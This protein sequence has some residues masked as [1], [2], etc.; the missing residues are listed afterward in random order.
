MAQVLAS[1]NA[2]S[3]TIGDVYQPGNGVLWTITQ[4]YSDV[5]G[6]YEWAA[7]RDNGVTLQNRNPFTGELA[8]HGL[9]S[10]NMYAPL[11]FNSGT[12]HI[13]N[14]NAPGDYAQSC[15]V[16]SRVWNDY[17][18][19]VIPEGRAFWLPRTRIIDFVLN[20]NDDRLPMFQDLAWHSNSGLYAIGLAGGESQSFQGKRDVSIKERNSLLHFYTW[21]SNMASGLC[22][23]NTLTRNNQLNWDASGSPNPSSPDSFYS[24]NYARP[25]YSHIEASPTGTWT[26]SHPYHRQPYN[27]SVIDLT[28]SVNRDFTWDMSVSGVVTL[29]FSSPQGGKAFL[30]FPDDIYQYNPTEL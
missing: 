7:T 8:A 3:G 13:I 2:P 27:V 18:V 30:E 23:V 24:W 16:L 4:V 6:I 12:L 19:S 21:S 22:V 15:G 25:V 10:G 20:P 17:E 14:W 5:S 29:T 28:A 11:T 1:K 26:I 9:T